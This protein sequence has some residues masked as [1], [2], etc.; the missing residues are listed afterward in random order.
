MHPVVVRNPTPI[1]F[2][3]M[4][5]EIEIS[6]DLRGRPAV[7]KALPSIVIGDQF[8]MPRQQRFRRSVR[9]LS[10]RVASLLL[11]AVVVRCQ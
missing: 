5:D 11:Q 1:L 8:S 3:L 6:V 10:D 7:R 9:E 4:H 2:G